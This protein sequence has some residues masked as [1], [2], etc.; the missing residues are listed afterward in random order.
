MPNLPDLRDVISVT[1]EA[2]SIL[3][4]K[5]DTGLE[6]GLKGA[7]EIVTEADRA[8]EAFLL[9]RLPNLLPG[10]GFFGE[11]TGYH[12]GDSGMTWVV[13]PLDG[14]HNYAL[15]IPLWACSVALLDPDRIP[16]LGVLDFP[17]LKKTLWARRGSGAFQNGK[18]IQVSRGPL[19]GTSALGVQSKIRMKNFPDHIEKISKQYSAR[20]LGAIAYSAAMVAVGRLRA[21]M[22]LKVKLHDI[23]AATVI[24]EEAG[25]WTRDLDGKRIFPLQ[26]EYE[27]L[28]DYPLPFFAGDPATGPGLLQYLFPNGIPPEIY[29]PQTRSAT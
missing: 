1:E 11:E 2:G 12:P 22:D 23:A 18:P 27:D 28:E 5:F 17:Y 4:E 16:V 6:I 8:S 15:G 13:D 24:V 25:G 19:D 9:E 20:T 7:D 10:S 14:T 21:C 26:K 29:E 3:L